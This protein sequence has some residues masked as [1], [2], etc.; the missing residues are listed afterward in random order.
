[1]FPYHVVPDGNAALPHHYVTLSV[2]SLVPLLMVWDHHPKRDP[3]VSMTA[4]LLGLM[5]FT[6]IWPRY[7]VIGAT[8]TVAC[9]VVAVLA[10]IA[11]PNWR[12]HWPRSIRVV[13][14]LLAL[15]AADDSLQHA[16]GWVTPIDWAWKHG[17]REAII[18]AF[19]GLA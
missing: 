1:M 5:S 19:S 7:P 17:G 8:L 15:G 16:F 18:S 11:L 9:N 13:A 3:W 4:V 14:V 10:P 12:H 2:L 6:L